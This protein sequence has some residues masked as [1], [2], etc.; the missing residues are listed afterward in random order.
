MLFELKPLSREAIPAALAE[1]ERSR[2]LNEPGQAESICRDILALEPGHHGAL[3]TLLLALTEQFDHGINMYEPT[4]L[5]GRL[6]DPY[7][8]A[9]Y[10]GIVHERRALALFRVSDFSA[11]QPVYSLIVE[12]LRGYEEAQKLRPAG[13][14]DSV[15]RWNACV[16]FLRRTPQLTSD[17]PSPEA[18]TVAWSE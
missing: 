6:G 13:N 3:V 7:E 15:L 8:K 2:L 10:L 14:D 11:A 18:A 16:R 9:Y 17:K 5:A 1:A 12:A 4:E